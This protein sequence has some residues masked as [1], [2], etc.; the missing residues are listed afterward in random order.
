MGVLMVII[1]ILLANNYLKDAHLR[2][3]KRE[4]EIQSE[5]DGNWP[6]FA[7]HEYE[8][9]KIL[10]LMD[11]GLSSTQS[12]EYCYSTF[13]QAEIMDKIKPQASSFNNYSMTFTPSA[14]KVPEDLL[15]AAKAYMRDR[16]N[17]L[18]SLN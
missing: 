5:K 1:V 16:S 17:Y 18:D 10:Y 11:N 3:E 15:K 12:H 13:L 2:R 4:D 7:V 9:G 8:S 6:F 14:K